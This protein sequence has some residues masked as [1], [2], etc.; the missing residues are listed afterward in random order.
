MFSTALG[1][2]KDTAHAEDIVQFAFLRIIKHIEKL[3]SLPHHEMK[4]YIVLVIKNLSIDLLRRRRHESA[5]S[6][7]SMDCGEDDSVEEIAL[8][9]LELGRIR[10][11]LKAMDNK[12]S[13][14]LIMKYSLGFTYIEIADMLGISAD[15]AKVRCHRGKR[16]L[17]D[18]ISREA[19]E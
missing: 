18:V 4:G 16:M 10:D 15:N 19:V 1:I 14:P 9:N 6:I 13:L 2:V 5:V 17:M 3:N 8:A 11:N 7:E 12:Y